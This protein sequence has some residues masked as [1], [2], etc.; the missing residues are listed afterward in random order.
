[1]LLGEVEDVIEYIS[2]NINVMATEDLGDIL[3]ILINVVPDKHIKSKGTGTTIRYRDIPEST[4]VDIKMFIE[5][6]LIGKR[7]KLNDMASVL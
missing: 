7:K 4:L 5:N 2:D 1:M 3:K 6:K